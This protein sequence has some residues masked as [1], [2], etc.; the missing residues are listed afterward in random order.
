MGATSY[1]NTKL[2]AAFPFGHGLTYTTFS[3]SKLD[4][5]SCS[6]PSSSAICVTIVVTNTGNVAAKA[7]PQLYLEFPPFAGHPSKM[8]KGFEK[9]KIISPG[10][11]VDVT[12]V[13]TDTELSYYDTPTHSW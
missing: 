9:T 13:L 8:L 10:Q 12:F 4:A 7:V 2:T 5:T 6:T 11:D 1:R 3:Y